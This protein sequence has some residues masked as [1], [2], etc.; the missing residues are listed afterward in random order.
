MTKLSIHLP[1]EGYLELPKRLKEF[2]IHS[3]HKRGALPDAATITAPM[4]LKPTNLRPKHLPRPLAEVCRELGKQGVSQV[5]VG[6]ARSST[7]TLIEIT[8][9]WKN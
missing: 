5:K 2:L 4:T 3:A 9:S 8:L 6:F 1:V 7:H